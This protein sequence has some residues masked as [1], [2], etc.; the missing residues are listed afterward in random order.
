MAPPVKRYTA[1]RSTQAGPSQS[2]AP[3]GTQATGSTQTQRRR[4]VVDED[5]DEDED[6]EPAQEDGGGD[7]EEAGGGDEEGV[8]TSG[9]LIHLLLID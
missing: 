8:G 9:I 5:E 2:Q 6:E 3:R 1:K 4:R 7:E